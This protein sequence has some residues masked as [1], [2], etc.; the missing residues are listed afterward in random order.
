MLFSVI[1]RLVPGLEMPAMASGLLRNFQS[2]LFPRLKAAVH[3][4]DGITLRGEL[5][6]GVR[7]HVTVLGITVNDVHRIPAQ[8]SQ[9]A[10]FFLRQIDRA[11]DVAFLKIFGL[12]H[13][14]DDDIRFF[15]DLMAYFDGAGGESHFVGEEL[16]AFAALPLNG[17]VISRARL[18]SNT[19]HNGVRPKKFAARR[20]SAFLGAESAR[21]KDDKANQQNQAKPAAADDGAAKIKPT[22]AEQ[23][24][25]NNQYQ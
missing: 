6:R 12:A 9:R 18:N 11:G 23:E 24:K 17:L 7:G 20:L 2:I 22:A 25:Q 15:P 14:H 16:L 1:H 21:E 13:V 19:D 4:H 5:H 10:P 8:T 3:F